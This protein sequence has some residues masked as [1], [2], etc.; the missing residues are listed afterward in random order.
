MSD[1]I[2]FSVAQAAEY[3]TCHRDTV[4]KAAEA[5]ELHGSQR[6]A[7]GHWRIHRDCLD[8]WLAGIECS[9]RRAS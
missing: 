7:R 6:K 2:W 9:H 5:S 3:A 1:R 8:A 4:R